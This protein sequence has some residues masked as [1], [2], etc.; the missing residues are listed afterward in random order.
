MKKSSPLSEI[1]HASNFVI[2]R[3]F[4]LITPIVFLLIVNSLYLPNIYFPKRDA[5]FVFQEFYYFY[6]NL[7]FNGELARWIP[8]YA[9][10]LPSN[11]DQIDSLTPVSYLAFLIGWVFKIKDVLFLFKLSLLGE[12]LVL[13]TGMYLLS[14]RL[15]SNRLTVFVVCLGVL[16][17]TY[18]LDLIYFHFRFF[19]LFPLA[20]YFFLNF[21]ATKR[22]EFFWLGAMTMLAWFMGVPS[23]FIFLWI[24]I[25]FIIFLWMIISDKE[26]LRPLFKPSV[27]NVL[28]FLIV[29]AIGL[30][31]YYHLQSFYQFIQ[32]TNRQR[33][34]KTGLGAF[35]TYG[36]QPDT[37]DHFVIGQY[38]RSFMLGN[39]SQAYLG[40]LLLAFWLL[41]LLKE[42]S[43]IFFVFL[44]ATI[45]L[46]WLSSSGIFSVLCY[47]F[48]PLMPYY[49][50][51]DPL[52]FCGFIKILILICAG[53][54]CEYF[55]QGKLKTKAYLILAA[56]VIFVFVLDNSKVTS[57]ALVALWYSE[58]HFGDLVK[59]ATDPTSVLFRMNIYLA[60]I[61]LMIALAAGGYILK[62]MRRIPILN[63]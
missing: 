26:I 20:T 46:I 57:D 42:R 41:A 35:L 1:F 2:N 3:R 33:G 19:Y 54:G 14:W 58:D 39:I 32:I 34:L 60:V 21:F 12:Q 31:I 27:T 11:Y 52:Y 49:R 44:S 24:F 5:L 17:S 29:L 9:Y 4:D 23:Y 36:A 40:L 18:W 30:C 55:W 16:G 59:Q 56:V 61:A 50:H 63:N 62:K 15:F 51:I 45:A 7:F 6:N 8:Y 22:P 48:F 38:L 13:L 10:G 43:K 28:L 53:F 47:Y 25:F 37:K